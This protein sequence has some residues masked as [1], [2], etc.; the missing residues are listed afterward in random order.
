[1]IGGCMTKPEIEVIPTDIIKGSWKGMIMTWIKLRNI[2]KK[3]LKETLK[4]LSI[5]G[6]KRV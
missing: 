5:N 2:S 4:K 3:N 1:V 6:R